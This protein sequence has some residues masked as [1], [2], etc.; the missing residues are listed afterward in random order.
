MYSSEILSKTAAEAGIIKWTEFEW[1]ETL[2]VAG[3]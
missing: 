3:S 1:K 2:K